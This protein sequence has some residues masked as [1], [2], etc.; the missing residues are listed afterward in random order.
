MPIAAKLDEWGK[1]AWI[2]AIVLGFMVFWPIGLLTLFYVIWSGRMGC[3]QRAG[4]SRWNR[5]DWRKWGRGGWPRYGF[6][7]SGNAAFDEYRNE[8]LKRLEEEEREFR[9]FLER[10]RAAKDKTEFDQFMAERRNRPSQPPAESGEPA[11]H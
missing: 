5:E 1:P 7:S 4:F 2:A 10:L 11:G 8:T 6:A 9:E 3:G